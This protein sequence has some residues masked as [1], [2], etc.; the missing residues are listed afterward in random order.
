[1]TFKKIDH[2]KTTLYWTFQSILYL[3]NNPSIPMVH[4]VYFYNNV[5]SYQVMQSRR[6]TLNKSQRFG[7]TAATIIRA[8]HLF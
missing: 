8:G 7:H 1:M 5:S 6:V 3:G 2:E 4:Q